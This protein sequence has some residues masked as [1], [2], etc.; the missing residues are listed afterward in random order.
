[1]SVCLAL[2]LSPPINFSMPE[3]IL[4][5]LVTLLHVVS[6]AN[7][8]TEPLQFVNSKNCV[9]NNF[10]KFDCKTIW[11]TQEVTKLFSSESI[12]RFLWMLARLYSHLRHLNEVVHRPCNLPFSSTNTVNLQV[13]TCYYITSL[14]SRVASERCVCWQ[15]CQCIVSNIIYCVVTV[16]RVDMSFCIM[17]GGLLLFLTRS[18]IIR[19]IKSID[20][21]PGDR[22]SIPSRG[23]GFF[24]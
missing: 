3:P 16:C 14:I 12:N 1:M 18:H 9:C 23:K 19:S 10:L 6:L 13:K 21:R 17:V 5:K 20:G 2:C 11:I 4:T 7:I 24:L 22:G 15:M 8:S